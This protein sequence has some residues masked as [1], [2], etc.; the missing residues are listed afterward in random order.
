MQWYDCLFDIL[1]Q[2]RLIDDKWTV[3]FDVYKT[4]KF[5]IVCNP[6]LVILQNN[7]CTIFRYN[8]YKNN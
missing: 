5:K 3:V 8:S 4:R 6:N 1:T 7:I 2:Q